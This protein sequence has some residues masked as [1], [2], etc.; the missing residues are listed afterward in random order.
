MLELDPY[1]EIPHPGETAM[2]EIRPSVAVIGAGISGLIAARLLAERGFPVTVFDKGQHPGGRSSTRQE[3]PY[4]FDHGCQY[5]T[6]R[7]KR[8]QRYVEAW[9]EKE[10]VSPWNA[11]RASCNRG[12]V[13]AVHDD[14]VRYVGVPGMNAIARHL[15]NGLDIRHGVQV[16]GLRRE[17]AGWRPIMNGNTIE[18]FEI[19]I[20]S[21]PA[22][23][24][25]QLLNVAP[26]LAADAARINMQP[27]WTA[28][29]AFDYDL[30]APFDAAHFSA[31]PLVWAARNSSKPGR[32]GRECWVLQASPSWSFEHLE[33][34]PETISRQLLAEFFAASGLPPVSPLFTGAH[35][36]RYASPR[37]S[38]KMSFLWDH[39]ISIGVCGDWCHSAR[40]E[41]A[42]LSGL[43]LAERIL[44]DRPHSVP[45]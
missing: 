1:R 44:D 10:I 39:D 25:H 7:D 27:C 42:F 21:A 20:V 45:R 3:G 30:D 15:A 23:Q 5:F 31:S 36:W 35:R 2:I 24:S 13:S 8:F 18:T 32:S 38:L 40:F 22:E 37:E 34:R 14:V 16:A 9:L 33:E 41:G 19:V 12:I 43:L 4:A 11:R 28:M 29:A 17:G 26:R 6:A